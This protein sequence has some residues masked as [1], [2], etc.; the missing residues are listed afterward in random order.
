MHF[1]Q[2]CALPVRMPVCVYLKIISYQFIST[3]ASL[4]L[5]RMVR[6][7]ISLSKA[8]QLFLSALQGPSPRRV[9]ETLVH[10]EKEALVN[11][12]RIVLQKLLSS[13]TSG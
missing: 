10:D 11:A 3:E 1:V 9:E 8:Q 5:E 13:P 2:H 12:E 6:P 7:E 4:I